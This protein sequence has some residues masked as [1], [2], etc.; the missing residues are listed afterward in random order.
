[1]KFGVWS[2]TDDLN[3]GDVCPKCNKGTLVDVMEE[4]SCSNCGWKRPVFSEGIPATPIPSG[5]HKYDSV[6]INRDD[7]RRFYHRICKRN[8]KRGAKICEICPFKK[9]ILDVSGVES[10]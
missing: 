10:D 2:K 9:Y 3:D 7:V 5:G 6:Q 4:L 1:M 8:L